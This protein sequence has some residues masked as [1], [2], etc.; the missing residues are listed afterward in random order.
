MTPELRARLEPLRAEIEQG[1][2]RLLDAQSGC[3]PRLSAAL[4]YSLLGPGKRL[5]P[6]L[7][8]L[9]CE[10]AGGEVSAALPAACAVE[11]VHAY[12]LVHDD[13]PGM[14]NDDWRRGRPTCHKQ[15]DEA[16]AILVGDGLLTLAFQVLAEQVQPP[17]VAAACVAD[18]ARGAG[19]LGMVGGQMDDLLAESRRGTGPAVSV[20][21]AAGRIQSAT[22]AELLQQ[23]ESI[24]RRK[25]GALFQAALRIGG[26]IG[27]AGSDLDETQS[28]ALITALD[29]FAAELGL[30]FQIADDLLDATG[31]A[32]LAGKAVQKDAGKGKLTYP[33]LLGIEAA[34]QHLAQA[35]ARALE[36]LSPFGERGRWLKELVTWMGQRQ[37]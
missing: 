25:T 15:F 18:L 27:A 29:G 6:I 33:G 23:L 30:A 20:P 13:L 19:V 34:R 28:S 35:T 32:Q 1:L 24:H 7:V 2:T 8:L 16:T 17:T 36:Q 10:A 22:A 3:P 31:D 26:R 14:D 11:L 5:R 9:A 37:A 21:V 4:R 12:S